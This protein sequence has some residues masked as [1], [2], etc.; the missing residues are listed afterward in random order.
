VSDFIQGQELRVRITR[1]PFL[2]E[3]T[4]HLPNGHTEEL[5]PDEARQWF[6]DHGVDDD[7][8]MEKVLDECWNFYESVLIIDAYREPVKPFPGYQPN[9]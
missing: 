5:M 7:E 9:V 2:D 8:G 1:Q 3:F 6:K 4:L